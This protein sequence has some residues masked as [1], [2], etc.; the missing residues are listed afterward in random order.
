MKTITESQVQVNGTSLQVELTNA[1]SVATPI[2]ALLCPDSTLI[3]Q[4]PVYTTQLRGYS[5]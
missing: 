4:A 5:R 3:A 1:T 2:C